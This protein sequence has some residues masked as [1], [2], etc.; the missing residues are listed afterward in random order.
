MVQIV[1]EEVTKAIDGNLHS[2]GKP[3]IGSSAEARSLVGSC[4]FISLICLLKFSLP[5]LC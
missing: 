2:S 3:N 5:E 1:L 4:I